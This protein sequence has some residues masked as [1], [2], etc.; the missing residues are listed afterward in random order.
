MAIVDPDQLAA[1]RRRFPVGDHVTGR[2]VHI[3]R[4]GSI[5]LLVDLGHQPEGFVD[6]LSLP[7]ESADWPSVGTLTTF[8]VLQHRPGQVRLLPLD[9]RFRSRTYLPSSLSD[10]RWASV[11]ARFPIGSEIAA[12]VTHLFSSNREYVVR[13]EDC[14]SSLDW[15]TEAPT[16]GATSTYSV[17]RH[18][19]HT[20]RIILAPA[21]STP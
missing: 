4:P 12:V 2:V 20:R 5:G 7:H 17:V 14:W 15:N 6:V 11:K 18:L 3:P 1:A 19:D 8:E 16:L 9:A 10:E 21:D 13:F